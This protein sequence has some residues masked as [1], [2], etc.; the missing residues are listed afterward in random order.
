MCVCVGGGNTGS[1]YSDNDPR[2]SLQC[3][4]TSYYQ[5]YC[6]TYSFIYLE[7]EGVTVLSDEQEELI[8][9]YGW[10]INNNRN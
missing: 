9:C 1:A 7:A 2:N 4:V 3:V 10:C 6:T 5:Q 8:L